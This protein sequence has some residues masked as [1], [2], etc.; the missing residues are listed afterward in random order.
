[1]LYYN[2]SWLSAKILQAISCEGICVR[3]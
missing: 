3:A 1:V 2:R